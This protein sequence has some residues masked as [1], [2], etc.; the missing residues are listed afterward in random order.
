MKIIFTIL[1]LQLFYYYVTYGLKIVNKAFKVGIDNRPR[2]LSCPCIV[3]PGF[4]LAVNN[5]FDSNYLLTSFHRTS[6]TYPHSI[7]PRISNASVLFQRIFSTSQLFIINTRW[8]IFTE[9]NQEQPSK[10]RAIS[11]RLWTR[12]EDTIV[13]A[14]CVPRLGPGT[15][16]S[17]SFF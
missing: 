17:R 8:T 14:S 15:S 16:S 10:C 4:F 12:C 1:K 9:F 13:R 3:L 5:T 11:N 7:L 2:K 6:I